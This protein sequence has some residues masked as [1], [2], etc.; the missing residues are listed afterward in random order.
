MSGD[1]TARGVPCSCSA[2]TLTELF[3]RLLG[4]YAE[5]TR[6]GRTDATVQQDVFLAG[7]SIRREHGVLVNT[8]GNFVIRPIADAKVC[9]V[10][11]LTLRV[12]R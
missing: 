11:F 5:E 6:F 10:V 3:A 7:L 2:F 8:D 9:R 4:L 1:S 12:Q